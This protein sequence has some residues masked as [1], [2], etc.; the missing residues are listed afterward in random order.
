MNTQ[1]HTPHPQALGAP[2]LAAVAAVL[3]SCLSSD[4]TPCAPSAFSLA[5][6]E[7]YNLVS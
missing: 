6:V 1:I 4:P 5:G 2:T 3:R 7:T